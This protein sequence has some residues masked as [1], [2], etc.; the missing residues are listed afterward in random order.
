MKKMYLL[1]SLA[2]SSTAFGQQIVTFEDLGLPQNS[3]WNGSDSTGG[4]TSGSVYFSNEY[5]HDWDYWSGGF[6]YSSSQNDT[7]PGYTNDY[8]AITGGGQNSPTYGVNYGGDIDFGALK[9]ISSIAVTNNT[10]AY[11][12]M[13]DGDFFGKKFGS[14]FNASGMADGTNGEDWFKLTIEGFDG[15][16]ISTGSVDFYLADFRFADSTQDYI[17]NTWQTVDLTSL[18]TVRYLNFSMSSSDNSGGF[19]NTPAYFALDNLTYGNLAISEASEKAL[20]CFPNPVKSTVQFTNA[21]PGYLQIS[22]LN[23]RLIWEEI[24]PEH[25]QVQLESI[26]AGTYIYSFSSEGKTIQGSLTK[27]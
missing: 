12:S 1:V 26:A 19:M 18:G 10:Y 5:N 3:V 15:D 7:T 20:T 16:S 27:Q 8:S 14:P 22:D 23:G 9:T 13:R 17:V 11:F 4:F 6:I 21:T 25:A 24:V 2:L